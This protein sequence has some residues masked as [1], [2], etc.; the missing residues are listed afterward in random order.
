[1]RRH[2]TDPELV[3]AAAPSRTVRV[4]RSDEELAEAAIRA[5]V[6]ARRLVDRLA[7]RAEGD[8]RTAAYR[9]GQRPEA[10]ITGRWPCA[11]SPGEGAG[12]P[13]AP[14]VATPAA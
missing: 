11:A 8:A 1:M 3:V 12:I 2:V 14:V 10:V 6:H 13:P 4:L 9:A 7:A 5:A